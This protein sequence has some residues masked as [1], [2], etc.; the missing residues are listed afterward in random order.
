MQFIKP[1]EPVLVLGILKAR[2]SLLSLFMPSQILSKLKLE[3]ML[4]LP[5]ILFRMPREFR[6]RLSK[7]LYW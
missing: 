3:E 1:I 2:F 4:V 7:L 5:P 6:F